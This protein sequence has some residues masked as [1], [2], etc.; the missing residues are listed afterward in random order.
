MQLTGRVSQS[1]PAWR[2]VPAAWQQP[3]WH[4]HPAHGAVRDVLCSAGP[5]VEATE[6]LA[7]REA[8]AAVASGAARVIQA[9]DCAESFA[10]CTPDGAAARI[11][12][13]GRLAERL[14][15]RTGQGV[16]QL[17]RMAG[18]FAKPRSSPTETVDGVLLPA[19]RGDLVNSSAPDAGSRRH[20]PHR[21]VRAYRASAEVM[22]GLRARRRG[23]LG[24][25][26]SH[27]ALVLDYEEALT[28]TAPG[29][30]G[31][32]LGSTHVPWVGARTGQLSGPHVGLLA[33][34]SNPVAC[35]IGPSTAPGD[36]VRLC[37]VL[38]PD[39]VPGRLTLIVR[40]GR[41]RVAEVLPSVVDA[42]RRAGHPVV[43]L[44]DPMHGN[45]FRAEC[46]VKTRRVADLIAEARC[47]RSVVERAGLHAGGLHLEVAAG[48]VTECLGGPVRDEAALGERYESLCDPRLNPEQALHLVDAVF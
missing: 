19:Y 31:R 5:L 29:A 41:D 23:G 38:D 45:T 13:L 42:V 25:W 10:D 22:A 43:W 36:V 12:V 17:G 2:E 18:Q 6:V 9:G 28:R 26:S 47:F 11:S 21:M 3:D 16:V 35:K 14:R 4:G 37:E 8:L 44:S 34:V 46:G 40:M 39:R 33:S 24:P 27:E 1:E 48:S 7:V 20:D 30:G 15:S 32:F